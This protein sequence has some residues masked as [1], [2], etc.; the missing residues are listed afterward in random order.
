MM[1]SL[2]DVNGDNIIDGRDATDILT[3]YAKTSTGQK[4]KYSEE[5]KKA[6]DVNND[7]IIDGRDATNILTYYAKISVGEKMTLEQFVKSI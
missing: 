4:S 1:Y 2:G 5:Q 6:A 7:V 3:E